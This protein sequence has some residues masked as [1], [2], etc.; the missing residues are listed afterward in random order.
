MTT[1]NSFRG[2]RVVALLITAVAACRVL[3]EAVAPPLGEVRNQML[4]G[5]SPSGGWTLD[6]LVVDASAGGLVVAVTAVASLLVLN[7]A[8]AFL[9]SVVA[10]LDALAA[11]ISPASVRRLAFALCGV[12][13]AAPAVAAAATADDSGPLP[14]PGGACPPSVTGLPLPDLPSSPRAPTIAVHYGESLWSIA[15]SE[16]PQQAPSSAVAA[17]AAHLYTA[18]RRIIGTN[19]DLIFPGQRLHAPGGAS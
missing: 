2:L 16:L 19:P 5:R 17:Q 4:E 8:A 15:A 9:G 13:L 11:G 6:R 1:L 10:P 3:T 7:M 14:S 12:A 18:N